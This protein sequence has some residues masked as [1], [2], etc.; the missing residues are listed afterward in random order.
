MI[1]R[2]VPAEP[3][4]IV[5]RI[6][7]L[8]VSTLR[9][10]FSDEWEDAAKEL[11][12]R[13]L[14]QSAVYLA[15]PSLYKAS[16]DWLDGKKL[17]N[18]RAPLRLLAYLVR[19]A[20]RTTPF[21]LFSG[22]ALAH[23][24]E[25][26]TLRSQGTEKAFTRTRPDMEWYMRFVRSIES[27]SMMEPLGLVRLNDL[28][29]IRGGRIYVSNVDVSEN[30][31]S[32]SS[33]GAASFA[34]TPG[35][36]LIIERLSES[37][38]TLAELIQ[39][40]ATRFSSD[41]PR[42][43]RFVETLYRA[44][45]FL[46]ATRPTLVG[47]PLRTL[48]AFTERRGSPYARQIADVASRFESLDGIAVGERRPQ[49]Y[50]DVESMLDAVTPGARHH[51]QTDMAYRLDGTVGA[52]VVRDLGALMSALMACS[53][54]LTSAF[55]RIFVERYES[56]E[57]EIPLL[58]IA[59]PEIGIG[60]AAFEEG[61][62]PQQP[63]RD[64]LLTELI[65][66]AQR[67]KSIEAAIDDAQFEQLRVVGNAAHPD[68]LE[69]SGVVIARSLDAI[70]AGDYVLRPGTI[71]GT[72][73]AGRSAGRFADL[74]GD[75]VAAKMRNILASDDAR[76]HVELVYQPVAYRAMN[77]SIRPQVYDTQLQIGLWQDE[78]V[79]RISPADVVV[80]MSGH[81]PYLRS[82]THGLLEIGETHLL[83]S[84]TAGSHIAQFVS[85]LSRTGK[86]YPRDFYWGQLGAASIFL[87]RLRY[88]RLILSLAKWQVP[89]ER[90]KTVDA[91]RETLMRYST[92]FSLPNVVSLVHG[93]NTLM[94]DWKTAS[95][96]ALLVDQV[97][98]L[99]GDFISLQETLPS[100]TDEQ[101]FAN[102][103][104]AHAFELVASFV[105]AEKSAAAPAVAASASGTRMCYP[106]GEWLYYKLYCRPGDVDHLLA[107]HI[108]PAM[109]RLQQSNAIDAWFFVRYADPK[110]H[111][112]VRLRVKDPAAAWPFMTGF[113]KQLCDSRIVQRF[114]IETY[115]REL[116]RYGG[117]A[118][119][120]ELAEDLFFF[121]TS[122]VVGI[123]GQKE[124]RVLRVLAT[125][126]PILRALIGNLE[127]TVA[128]FRRIQIKH[129]SL[130]NEDRQIV[131]DLQ[132]LVLQGAQHEAVLDV[133][134]KLRALIHGGRE[135]DDLV[136]SMLH[137]HFNRCGIPNDQEPRMLNM[138]YKAYLGALNQARVP[139]YA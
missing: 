122:A 22:V 66:S 90:L 65:A 6:A 79:T 131:R 87:P 95:G 91:A 71:H 23:S 88:G 86:R 56:L 107:E 37:A 84:T 12:Q 57:R 70:E 4:L 118:A 30:G 96:M 43:Q 132:Q 76:T 40:I 73:G 74:L 26:T 110:P 137:M 15:S 49:D 44:G 5:G 18:P 9:R 2:Y 61:A 47:D 32:L 75:E 69:F 31:D 113:A 126:S 50:M 52:S 85:L 21:G 1:S 64:H 11:L 92:E 36:E 83:N 81:G 119:A 48:G 116:E 130:V 55:E 42:A 14:V 102:D 34:M 72:P 115:V 25:S 62:A 82:K 77:L 28:A 78:G 16:R 63:M 35:V 138:L 111:L 129:E 117:S 104:E 13:P 67:A 108:G 45:L 112:R 93:D 136:L 106:G 58:E 128:F 103:G 19:M 20:S 109:L 139:A 99:T 125:C 134:E 29:E 114:S 121:D 27:A 135:I 51:V 38:A 100:Y 54:P 105:N 101:W 7:A 10:L 68:S 60:P 3:P 33:T 53:P 8:P 94:L 124:G 97:A 123:L 89:R 80:G 17:K 46:P 127:E 39:A 41:I 120:C 98:A 133:G 24:G 59:D